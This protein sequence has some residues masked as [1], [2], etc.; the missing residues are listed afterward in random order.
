MHYFIFEKDGFSNSLCFLI[1]RVGIIWITDDTDEWSDRQKL[2][3]AKKQ[4]RRMERK[5]ISAI[6]IEESK[7]NTL[8]AY[9]KS[10]VFYTK[11]VNMMEFYRKKQL[12]DFGRKR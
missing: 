11:I 6:I 7:W 10:L 12:N 2:S 1:P 8:K 9:E 3:H 4:A 5:G